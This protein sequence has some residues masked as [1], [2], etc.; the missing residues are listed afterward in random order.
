L[1]GL[2]ADLIEG[3]ADND[4]INGDF[5]NDTILGGVG[6][7]TINGGSDN[8]LILGGDNGDQLNGASGN[9]TI[10]GE[11]GNDK[12]D[13]G[14]QNDLLNGGVGNDTINGGLTGD[15]TLVGGAGNDSLI[16]GNGNDTYFFSDG[17]TI[18]E[19]VS[20]GTNDTVISD[21][22][23]TLDD[24]E[25]IENIIIIGDAKQATGNSGDNAI[26][27]NDADNTLTGGAG[28]DT[29][30]G[31]DAK[32]RDTLVGGVGNDVY[33]VHDDK[34]IIVENPG[35]GTDTVLAVSDEPFTE[36]EG[37]VTLTD[38]DIENLILGDNF[39]TGIGNGNDN[40]VTGN[41]LDNS[42][43]GGL[44][45][46]TLDGGLG[47]DTMEGD[48]GDDL[49]IVDNIGD[50][51]LENFEQGHDTVKSSVD[52]KLDSGN[53]LEDLVLT[54]SNVIHGTGNALNNRITGNEAFNILDG[55]LGAD[56]L[57]GGLGDDSYIVD[58]LNDKVIEN[59]DGGRDLVTFS[60]EK[61]VSSGNIEVIQFKLQSGA[62]EAIGDAGQNLIIG[63]T[64]F[65]T[66]N[67]G[68]GADTLRGGDGGD[69]YIVDDSNDKIEEVFEGQGF[70]IIF[71]SVDFELENGSFVEGLTL[72]GDAIFGIGNDQRNE[73]NG[74]DLANTLQGGAGDDL[75]DGKAGADLLVGGIGNDSFFVS[76]KADQIVEF[77]GEGTD[78]VFTTGDFSLSGLANVENMTF[79]GFSGPGLPNSVW[80]ATGN[81]ADNVIDGSNSA[82]S[83][84]AAGGGND[85]ILTGREDNDVGT[86]VRGGDGEDLI[87]FG[88]R[89][90]QN[91]I[92]FEGLNSGL[93]IVENF[94][95][96]ARG[97]ALG[98]DP[99]DRSPNIFLIDV[100]EDAVNSSNID[101]HLRFINF[102]K[103][104]GSV[105]MQV[106][107]DGEG[108]DWET[109]A[110]FD[111]SRFD[112]NAAAPGF[113]V[114]ALIQIDN[115]EV[116]VGID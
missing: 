76:S 107:R 109:I 71:S 105:E 40:K 52:F 24:D 65:N 5:G 50:T 41:E 30:D 39:V 8:D 96:N 61:F 4:I 70:D 51:I 104:A 82:V 79:I 63:N 62:K 108:D 84:I 90:R 74:N 3:G 69:T 13:G 45:N 9:D 21:I 34:T 32:F 60:S 17:D 25:N 67:G 80:N 103:T 12:L 111:K 75:L 88:V 55:G 48:L 78:T 116:S 27:G 57:I 87:T 110:L 33:V 92:V 85:W 16:G 22:D 26:T 42:L 59:A 100:F 18:V 35:E 7:D 113:D 1:G 36:G 93:D 58:D 23:F 14:A 43:R 20:G 99:D 81:D 95:F 38:P 102:D 72:T 37:T 2:D 77:A 44:G 10:E 46:D 114:R 64:G 66:L 29:L 68:A 49:Y 11:D 101:S 91:V 19:D 31:G 54:G 47:A 106:N 15:D 6:F 115:V 112:D 28:N 89:D 97:T 53:A 83:S 56:T 94:V 86:T 98:N 73:I